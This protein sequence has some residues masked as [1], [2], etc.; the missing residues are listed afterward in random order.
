M[1]GGDT[2][3]D[4]TIHIISNAHR[5]P[6]GIYIHVYDSRWCFLICKKTL[7]LGI[8][9]RWCLCFAYSTYILYTQG[10]DAIC[11][12]LCVSDCSTI[13]AEP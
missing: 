1:G 6:G 10:T 4:K 12:C 5:V 3:N 8:H 2:H 11:T 9:A 7:L 13:L